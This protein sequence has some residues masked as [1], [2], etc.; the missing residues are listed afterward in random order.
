MCRRRRCARPPLGFTV[1]KMTRDVQ[2]TENNSGWVCPDGTETTINTPLSFLH[3]ERKPLTLDEF[4]ISKR[5][6]GRLNIWLKRNNQW[7]VIQVFG[8]MR[9]ATDFVAQ[10]VKQ[11]ERRNQ[12]NE[13]NENKHKAG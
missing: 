11:M 3:P 4:E 1:D 13:E 7:Q 8:S 5:H 2:R 6:D 9:K 10:R 12:R